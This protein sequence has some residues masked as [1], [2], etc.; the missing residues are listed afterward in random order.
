MKAAVIIV[1]Y[2]NENDAIDA[3]DSLR[4]QVYQ[5]WLCIIIDN[6]STDATFD[7]VKNNIAG[8]NR[9][10]AFQKENEGPASGRNFG[11]RKVEK[12]TQY[13]HFLDGDDMLHSDFL[14]TM[15]SYLDQHPEVGLLGCQY[16]KVDEAGKFLQK[17]HRSRY[18][19][20][21]LGFPQNL[22]RSTYCT[23]FES[24]F[25]ATGQGS[26]ALY[27]VDVLKRTN[28]FEESFWS[29]EDSDMFCQMSLL[30]EVH[31]LPQRLYN[32]RIRQNSLSRSKKLPQNRFRDKWDLYQS[33]IPGENQLIERALKYY[34]TRHKPMRDFKVA[35]KA[36]RIFLK[37]L[38]WHQL[39]WA[40]ECFEAGLID[41]LVR[42]SYK[43]RMSERRKQ[44]L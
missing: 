31:Y 33:D 1:T 24:F 29:H 38:N 44:S 25:S 16:N 6:G 17:G 12:D 9:F 11:F 27:R 2:N 28:G 23:P 15:I 42:R 36:S 21:F 40:F 43:N 35:I 32:V 3:I 13:V 19:S 22:K 18:H 37:S 14:S 5:D 26:F 7:L 8:D 39:R 20:G 34:Y 30:S 4:R 10:S 41:V